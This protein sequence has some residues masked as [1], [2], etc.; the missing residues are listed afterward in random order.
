M[1]DVARGTG[2]AALGPSVIRELHAASTG[3][4]RDRDRDRDADRDTD[5]DT[6]RDTGAVTGSGRDT[7]SGT[8]TDTGT[9]TDRGTD[10]DPEGA[11]ETQMIRGG[12]RSDLSTGCV[13]QTAG[14]KSICEA[15]VDPPVKVYGPLRQCPSPSL[16]LNIRLAVSYLSVPLCLC[17]SVSLSCSVS[18]S[19]SVPVSVSV[20]H[21]LS[22]S[23]SVSLQLP[24]SPRQVVESAAGKWGV[25]CVALEV[26]SP[27]QIYTAIHTYNLQCLHQIVYI[28]T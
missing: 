6:G 15:G 22:V 11:V 24:L 26:P 23:I 28:Q 17:L 18:V 9:D 3:A 4:D 13:L 12:F 7:G 2:Q 19:V 25:L 14:A 8:A 5:R 21:C 27:Y 1:T 10:T 20:S 16:C